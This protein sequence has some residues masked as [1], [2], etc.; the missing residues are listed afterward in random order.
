M[1]TPEQGPVLEPSRVAALHGC[2]W[3]VHENK[4]GSQHAL[5]S[6]HLAPA[7]FGVDP[8][9]WTVSAYR[10]WAILVLRSSLIGKTAWA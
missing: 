3:E 10:R 9:A 6:G 2:R 4:L 8:P 7:A 1:L 5:S